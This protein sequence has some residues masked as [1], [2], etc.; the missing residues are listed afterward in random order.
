M[1]GRYIHMILFPFMIGIYIHIMGKGIK[2]MG[3]LKIKRREPPNFGGSR[4]IWS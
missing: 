4:S 2:G 3:L 1:I